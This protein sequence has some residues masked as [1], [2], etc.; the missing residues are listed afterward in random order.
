VPGERP[1]AVFLDFDGTLTGIA[2]RPDGVRVDPGLP[3]LLARLRDA[4]DGALALVSG[5]AIATLDELIGVAGLCVAGL[6]GLEWRLP[7]G[8]TARYTPAPG[9]LDRAR[10]GLTRF[11][12]GDPRLLLEDKG[13]TLALHY[14]AAPERRAACAERIAAEAARLEGYHVIEG[15][16][17]FEL[18]PAVAN[19]GTAIRAM[20]ANPDFA[21]RLPVFAG[22][23]MT[24]ED[25]FAAVQDLGGFGVKVGDGETAAIY[26]VDDVAALVGWL[27]ALECRIST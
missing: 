22:D 16:R 21:G 3:P 27:E 25:G 24:D 23:D 4:L 5:R 8:E 2:A 6:H 10:R 7:R 11:V 15:K 17:V 14:R 13:L 12:A 19:K 18:K 9:A 26:R 20:M 1:W